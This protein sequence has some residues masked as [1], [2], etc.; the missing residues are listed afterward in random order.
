MFKAFSKDD[1]SLILGFLYLPSIVSIDLNGDLRNIWDMADFYHIRERDFR[2]GSI[3]EYFS[4]I[5]FDLD[6]HEYFW[7]ASCHK[8]ENRC[9]LIYVLD[10]NN[11]DEKPLARIGYP[12]G[13]K[14]IRFLMNK[15]ILAIIDDNREVALYQQ[16]LD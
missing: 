8:T 4:A 14:K 6:R 3:P 15:T 12:S 2:R 16:E 1:Q 13:I 10:I 5:S 7:I 9:D 11:K